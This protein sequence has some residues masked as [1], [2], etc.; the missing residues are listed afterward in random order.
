MWELM[1]RFGYETLPDDLTGPKVHRLENVMTM[2][3]SVHSLYDQLMIW[4]T[5]TVRQFDLDI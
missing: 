3:P 2:D 1:R 4:L 5:A